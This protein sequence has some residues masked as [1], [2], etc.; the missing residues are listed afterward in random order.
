MSISNSSNI[1][2]K[3]I[4]FLILQFGLWGGL[5]GNLKAQNLTNCRETYKGNLGQKLIKLC[6]YPNDEKDTEISGF[7]FRDDESEGDKYFTGNRIALEDGS[8]YH[9]LIEKNSQGKV[10]GY[11]IGIARN[12]TLEGTWTSVDG[13]FIEHYLLFIQV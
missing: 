6:F 1:Q 11:F 7:Y 8:Y 3:S 12:G 2:L 4:F 13:K 10:S 9:H 5:A